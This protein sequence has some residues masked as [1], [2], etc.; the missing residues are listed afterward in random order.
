[1]IDKD[2]TQIL[3]EKFFPTPA[4]LDRLQVASESPAKPEITLNPYISAEEVLKII[5]RLLNRKAAGPDRILNEVLKRLASEISSGLIQR[6]HVTLTRSSLL[7]QYKEL[8]MIVLHK[9]S[10]KD[11]FLP[12]SYKLI[13]LKNMLIKVIKK[14]LAT[15]FSIAAEVHLMLP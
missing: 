11:Y 13:T 4:S 1:M 14:V 5:N 10:K 9:E 7:T 12:E 8:I 3:I 6:I 2:R 15:H